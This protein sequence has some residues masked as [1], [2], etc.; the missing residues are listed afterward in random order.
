MGSNGGGRF[1]GG[2]L[3]LAGT[4]WGVGRTADRP[5]LPLKAERALAAC[6]SK[7]IVIGPSVRTLGQPFLGPLFVL[8]QREVPRAG[9]L[10][11]APD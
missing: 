8:W 9:E 5:L 6:A 10:G 4:Y 11:A 7:P 3:G 1:F 2:G